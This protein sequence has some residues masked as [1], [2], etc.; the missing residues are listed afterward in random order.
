MTDKIISLLTKKHLDLKKCRGQSYD[1]AS[2]MSGVYTGVQQ[3]IKEKCEHALFVHCSAH[4]L[5]LVVKDSIEGNER[6]RAFFETVQSVYDFF[7]HSIVHWRELQTVS[8][9]EAKA[10]A[11][12]TTSQA[13]SLIESKISN[14]VLKTLNPTRWAGRFD[15]VYALKNRFIDV[16]KSLSRIILTS[17]KSKERTK[18]ENLKSKLENFEFVLLLVLQC[19]ILGMINLVSKALQSESIELLCAHQMLEK[20]MLEIT[21]LRQNFEIIKIE[22]LNICNLWGIRTEFQQKRL[23]K[24]KKHFD[25]LCQDERLEEPEANFKATVFNPVMDTLFTQI[26]SR[27]AGMKAVLD[28]YQIIQPEFLVNASENIIHEKALH[29]A[30]TF[31]EDISPDFPSQLSSV[32][33]LFQDELKKIKTVKQFADMIIIDYFS[34][35]SS[36]PDVCTACMMYLT[37]P[38]TVAKAERSFSKL[39]LIKNYLRSTMA[40]E[41]LS[42]LALISIEND[43]AQ[44]LD[45]EE[46]IEQFVNSKGYRRKKRFM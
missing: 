8:K 21:E 31:S 2:V 16:L 4:N 41:R 12:T 17:N 3:R 19:K 40:Q 43:V 24:V 15:A 11:S 9:E 7:G 37:L 32:R 25:E 5:A 28:V 18:A 33:I 38:V 1:G 34:L 29:F 26:H 36:Y 44:Q 13:K 22:A 46:I 20:V 27:F 6:V 45:F 14:V 23:R 39:K 42:S 30:N 35:S 10:R